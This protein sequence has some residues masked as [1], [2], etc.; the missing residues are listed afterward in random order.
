MKYFFL[1][2]ALIYFCLLLYFVQ[3]TFTITRRP[4]FLRLIAYVFIT[5]MIMLPFLHA[6]VIP[7]LYGIS[8]WIRLGFLFFCFLFFVSG[9]CLDAVCFALKQLNPLNKK[10]TFALTFILMIYG[11]YE[12]QNITTKK[13]TLKS[14]KISKEKPLK[15]AYISDVHI[16]IMSSEKLLKKTVDIILQSKPDILLCGGDLIDGPPKNEKSL[17]VLFGSLNLP[18]GK[19]SVMGN[20]ET[21]HG[22]NR[23]A[24]TIKNLGFTLLQNQTVYVDDTTAITGLKYYRTDSEKEQPQEKQLLNQLDKNKY[25]ILVKHV[26][27]ITPSMPEN[28]D[29]Q[30]SGHTHNGQIFPFV[31]FV[32]LLYK[33]TYGIYQIDKDSFLYVS[34]GSGF[35]EIPVRILAPAE[36][37]LI[38]IE[39]AD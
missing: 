33:Y 35:W 23:S 22:K 34:S 13:I 24:Q 36:I 19:Y 4:F 30:L 16:G 21:Y 26:P 3:K 9:I 15:I 7:P 8:G 14:N 25:N 27:T 6:S 28:I 20:H 29:L 31:Y 11:V 32:K 5:T 38:T 37:V 2:Y 17:S 10:L 12:S 18:L 1:T 39:S